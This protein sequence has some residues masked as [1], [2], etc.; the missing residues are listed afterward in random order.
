MAPPTKQALR[1]TCCGMK[2]EELANGVCLECTRGEHQVHC[3]P[4]APPQ[5][6]ETPKAAQ[7]EAPDAAP[8]PAT[9]TPSSTV[10]TTAMVPA[11]RREV[12]PIAA[13]A[14]GV[15]LTTLDD[16]WR[17]SGYVHQ[18]GLA[19]T[20]LESREACFLAIE[21]GLE[22]GMPPMMAL[23]N[24]AVING[25]P[26]PYGAAVKGIVEASGKMEE[27]RE[28]FEGSY[29]DD[30]FTAVVISKRAGRDAMR[31]EFSIGDA[32]TAK[33]WG[34]VGANGKPTP[35]V[36]FPKRMLMWRARQFNFHDNFPDVTRGFKTKEELEDLDYIDVTPEPPITLPRRTGEP[37]P[38]EAPAS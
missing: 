36:T 11:P 26:G 30:S 27:Y 14:R 4:K 18:S 10:A 31:S 1:C 22:L 19:P 32:K 6:A 35:W 25:K 3:T 28:F 2:S 9:G 24:I 38:E 7:A 15:V 5:A 16:I 34:K 17:F 20:G 37:K 12:A 13:Q 21:M 8:A 23:Q 33:L 29:P